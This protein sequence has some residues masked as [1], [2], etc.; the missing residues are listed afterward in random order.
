[1][2]GRIKVKGPGR[3]LFINLN[4]GVSTFAYSLIILKSLHIMDKLLFSGFIPFK[5]QIFSTARTLSASHPKAYNVSVGYIT[6]PPSCRADTTLSISRV[7]GFSLYILISIAANI[8]KNKFQS[9]DWNLFNS[10]VNLFNLYFSFRQNLYLHR[11]RYCIASLHEDSYPCW[12]NLH[13]YIDSA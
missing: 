1:V 6:I 5:L 8:N 7:F 12:R 2:V 4:V 3:F 9:I 11:V 13:H 10:S